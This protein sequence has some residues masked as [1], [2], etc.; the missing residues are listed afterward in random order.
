ME[1]EPSPLFNTEMLKVKPNTKLM[2][3]YRR[4]NPKLEPPTTN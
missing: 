3:T 2:D 4:S 1:H